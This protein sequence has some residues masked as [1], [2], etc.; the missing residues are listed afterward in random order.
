MKPP[1]TR[2]ATIVVRL[3]GEKIHSLRTTESEMDRLFRL[4]S[5]DSSCEI[6]NAKP[7]RAISVPIV[8]TSELIRRMA[9]AKPCAA[10]KAAA[11][12]TATRRQG[13]TPQSET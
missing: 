8:K 12:A 7:R 6:T 9:I 5:T 11:A 2:N 10:P 3:N 4:T 1:K 13:T